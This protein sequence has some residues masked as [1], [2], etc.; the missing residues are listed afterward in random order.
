MML[1]NGSP[2]IDEPVF[3]PLGELVERSAEIAVVRVDRRESATIEVERQRISCGYVYEGAAIESLKG[4]MGSMRFFSRDDF[5]GIGDYLVLLTRRPRD[6][7]KETL[8]HD[9]ASGRLEPS[10]VLRAQ[11]EI[12]AAE[13]FVPDFPQRMI[14]FDEA[15]A[16]R[17]TGKWLRP[18]RPSVISIESFRRE[19][20][21]L[22]TA[23]SYEVVSWEDVRE[24]L[25]RE[26]GNE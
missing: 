4:R 14:K 21:H 16:T 23:R 13:Y 12:E 24:A 7:A 3:P 9:A 5:Q 18:T 10:D 1:G 17:L 25:R 2:T 15:A 22:G 19:T 6:L 26:I 20:I 8:R 11:C